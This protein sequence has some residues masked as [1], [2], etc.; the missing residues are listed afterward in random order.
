MGALIIGAVD[1]DRWSDHPERY[2]EGPQRH[3]ELRF[4]LGEDDFLHPG[5]IPA[6]VATRPADTSVA[7]FVFGPLPVTTGLHPTTFFSP[8]P[9]VFD[10]RDNRATT[11]GPRPGPAGQPAAGL[12]PEARVGRRIVK[13]HRLSTPRTGSNSDA[14]ALEPVRRGEG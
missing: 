8:A 2:G 3:V 5:A 4:L 11:F 10:E 13:V 6:A 14:G 12:H 1:Q 9:A 7:P